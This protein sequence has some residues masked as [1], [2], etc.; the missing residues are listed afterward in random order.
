MK[1]LFFY[2]IFFIFAFAIQSAVAQQ[3]P[4]YNEI[5]QFR[6]SDSITLPPA[7]ALLFIGSSSFTMW[8]DV[9]DYFPGK[10][11]INRGFGGSSLPHLIMYFDDI[12]KPYQPK[13][14]IIYCGENDLT[15]D[16]TQPHHV[17]QR[18]QQLFGMI[19]S[20]YP[21]VPISF[22]SIKPSP[23]RQKLMAKMELSNFLIYRFL[24]QQTNATYVNVY[25]DML[26]SGKPEPSLFIADNLHMNAKGYALWKQKIE[27]HLVK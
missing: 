22:I 6:K 12:V 19:R 1:R 18:F 10:N 26:H 16:T 13:Q 2:I 9:Q 8:R 20:T 14:V 23:S 7:N 5:L 21:N 24:Q 4:F 15:V 11:I 27:P 3:K 25:N 17:L